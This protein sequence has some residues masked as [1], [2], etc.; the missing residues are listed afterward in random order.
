MIAGA[1]EIDINTG[2]ERYIGNEAKICNGI[3]VL[4]C[5]V[6]LSNWN[7][8]LNTLG[9]QITNNQYQIFHTIWIEDAHCKRIRKCHNKLKINW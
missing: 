1:T 4:F 2:R 9:T 3:F 6:F 7:L 8:D 5:I